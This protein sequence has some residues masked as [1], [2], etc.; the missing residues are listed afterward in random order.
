MEGSTRL[1][2]VDWLQELGVANSAA[3][4]HTH[5]LKLGQLTRGRND[6]SAACSCHLASIDGQ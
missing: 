2:K 5:N 6:C 1:H 4:K 3:S